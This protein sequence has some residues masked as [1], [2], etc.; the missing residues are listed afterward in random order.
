MINHTGKSWEKFTSLPME[1]LYSNII[2][3][4][5]D[6]LV[7]IHLRLECDGKLGAIVTKCVHLSHY[8][9]GTNKGI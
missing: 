1:I 3:Q 4:I 7:E 2:L 6:Y 5:H 9:K 8:S